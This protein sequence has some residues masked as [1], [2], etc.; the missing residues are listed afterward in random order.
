MELAPFNNSEDEAE[1]LYNSLH[2]VRFLMFMETEPF[3]NKY[4]QII[5]DGAQFKK[6]SDALASVS[7]SKKNEEGQWVHS[8]KTST[9]EY[10][11]PDLREIE[12][13]YLGE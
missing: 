12:G 9:E 6:M 13:N 10:P 4:Y 8:T 5:L 3:S 7:I 1:R 11:L 2:V